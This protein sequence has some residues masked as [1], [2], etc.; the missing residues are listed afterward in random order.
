MNN[1]L[2]SIE[3]SDTATLWAAVSA[4]TGAIYA[5]G[6]LDGNGAFTILYHV[7]KALITEIDNRMGVEYEI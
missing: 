4:L 3:I 6:E 5:S 2:I 7:Y 1:L